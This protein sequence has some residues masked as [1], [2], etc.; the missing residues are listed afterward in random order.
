MTYGLEQL[1]E[2]KL[3]KAFTN[4]YKQYPELYSLQ[5]I[6]ECPSCRKIEFYDVNSKFSKD[7]LFI[8][9]IF[10][11]KSLLDELSP[12]LEELIN[13]LYIKTKKRFVYQWVKNDSYIL[14]LHIDGQ[15]NF[16]TTN[17]ENFY[18]LFYSLI[19]ILSKNI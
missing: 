8:L 3:K 1:Y 4:L 13:L 19:L 11:P 6:T 14:R 5:N 7:T 18:K 10:C 16:F 15:D 12:K 2:E 17:S 9:N